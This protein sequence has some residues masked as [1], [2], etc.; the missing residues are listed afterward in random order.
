[1][2]FL[3]TRRKSDL[4]GAETRQLR[5]KILCLPPPLDSHDPGTVGWRQYM[6]NPSAPL[7][8]LF[9]P[10]FKIPGSSLI[11]IFLKKTPGE[12]SLLPPRFPLFPFHSL[13]FSCKLTTEI[14][15][16]YIARYALLMGVSMMNDPCTESSSICTAA[17]RK[18]RCT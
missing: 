10:F 12:V 3:L 15:A 6:S 5:H 8:S 1:M 13:V 17:D 9:H 16:N 2:D 4:K 18:S 7:L 11:Q 14:Y